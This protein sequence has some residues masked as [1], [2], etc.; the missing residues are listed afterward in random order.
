MRAGCI[1]SERKNKP[2][3]A[4]LSSPQG[5]VPVCHRIL[6]W[7]THRERVNQPE[8]AVLPPVMLDSVCIAGYAGDPA[9]VS[10]YIGIPLVL[11]FLQL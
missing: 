1:A 8:P 9:F 5:A 10:C 11:C 7:L 4:C 6:E 2:S 3:S